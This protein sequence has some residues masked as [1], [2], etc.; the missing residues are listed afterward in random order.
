MARKRRHFS[1]NRIPK[2]N[3]VVHQVGTYK[4]QKYETC[5]SKEKPACFFLLAQKI[6]RLEVIEKWNQIKLIQNPRIYIFIWF[7]SFCSP[8]KSH[9]QVGALYLPTYLR[10]LS[11]YD[12][13]THTQN[14]KLNKKYFSVFTRRLRRRAT[15]RYRV[16]FL[17]LL[18][19]F[20]VEIQ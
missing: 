10:K 12:F 19:L 18:L 4:K 2:R 1:T 11:I 20:G 16:V 17:L 15:K 9:Y 7:I 14:R 3:A 8:C 6:I 5:L 13:A